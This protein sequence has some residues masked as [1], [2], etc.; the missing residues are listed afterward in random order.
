MNRFYAATAAVALSLTAL[1]TSPAF[2]R[3]ITESISYAD[4]DLN[5]EHGARTMLQRIEHAARD[6]CGDTNGRITLSERT[7]VRRCVTE[8]KANAVT[9]LN[10]PTVTAMHQGAAP[11]MIVAGR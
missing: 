9:Q 7:I 3:D 8:T 11:A 4:I 1:T 6:V 10:N 2:A 5:T